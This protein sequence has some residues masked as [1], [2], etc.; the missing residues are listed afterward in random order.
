MSNS[1]MFIEVGFTGDV[2]LAEALL[3]CKRKSRMWDVVVRFKFKGP[4][5]SVDG[6]ASDEVIEGLYWEYL[7]RSQ[8][9]PFKG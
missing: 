2:D 6:E 5:F 3:E 9:I 8:T 4:I 1:K 7:E